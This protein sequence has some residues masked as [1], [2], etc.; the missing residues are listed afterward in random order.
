M[1]R[2]PFQLPSTYTVQIERE[3]LFHVREKLK[4]NRDKDSQDM[5]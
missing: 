5:G 1:N 2:P 4:A 3:A